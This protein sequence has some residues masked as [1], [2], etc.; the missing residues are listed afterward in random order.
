MLPTAGNLNNVQNYPA[1]KNGSLA[2]DK[3]ELRLRVQF[4]SDTAS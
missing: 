1:G 3:T 2:C 4:T